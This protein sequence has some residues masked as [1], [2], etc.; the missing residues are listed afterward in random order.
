MANVI[1]IDQ[2]TGEV[3]RVNPRR[4]REDGD[5][6]I[7]H[8]AGSFV[9]GCMADD[10]KNY[11]LTRLGPHSEEAVSWMIGQQAY[12]LYE[13]DK[14]PGRVLG[15]MKKLSRPPEAEFLMVEYVHHTLPADCART[16]NDTFCIAIAPEHKKTAE[17]RLQ[18]IQ[19]VISKVDA[20]ERCIV[21]KNIADI[22]ADTE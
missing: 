10:Q 14:Y 3:C 19:D 22:L 21:Y 12:K 6:L 9:N 5:T 17:E 16:G 18:E 7:C 15:F 8:S 1:V 2:N 13:L 20:E 4:T 11:P